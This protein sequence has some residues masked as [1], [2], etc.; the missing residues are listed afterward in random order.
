[1]TAGSDG[2][3]WVLGGGGV[4]GIAWEIGILTGLAT[5]GVTVSPDATLIGTSAGAVV[6]AQLTSGVPIADLYERQQ[7][8]VPYETS[9]GLGFAELLRLARAPMFARSPEDAGRRIGRLALDVVP[10][11]PGLLHRVVEARLPKHD[12][13][14][15]TLWVV[16]VDAESGAVRVF[17]RADRVSLW[18]P[19]PRAARCLWHRRR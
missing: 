17:T 3:V 4:A 8:G 14:D 12:W 15:A 7:R 11:D 10:A 18:M 9:P 6:G 5:E 19:W 2:P 13:S 1:M 16:T